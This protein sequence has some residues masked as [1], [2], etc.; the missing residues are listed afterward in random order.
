MSNQL[1]AIERGD[2]A[3]KEMEEKGIKINYNSVAK[4]ANFTHRMFYKSLKEWA[5]LKDDVD[6]AQKRQVEAQLADDIDKLRNEIITL[7]KQLKEEKKKN[8]ENKKTDNEYPLLVALQE[9]Y[10]LNDILLGENNDNK[11]NE[12]HRNEGKILQIDSDSGEIINPR[13]A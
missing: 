1:S 10:R 6:A 3:L 13:S 11:N 12:L 7:K 2:A 5:D 9:T 8:K 4:Y